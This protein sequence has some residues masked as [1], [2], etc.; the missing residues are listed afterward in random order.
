MSFSR[1][2]S[3]G[4][5]LLKGYKIDVEVDISKGLNSFTIVGLPD[6]S[7]SEAK[8]RVSAAIK[9][10]GFESPKSKNQKVV[11]SLAPANL[12]KEGSNFDLAMALAYLLA[13]DVIRFNPAKKIFLGEL[14]LGGKISPIQ[15]ALLM[16]LEAKRLGFEE[17]YLPFQNLETVN[18]VNGIKIFGISHLKEVIFHLNEKDREKSG[19][20]FLKPAVTKKITYNKL[21]T[22]VDFRD[23]KGQEHVKRAL[24]ISASGKHNIMMYGPPGTGKTMLAKAYSGI[25]PP[26]QF[27]EILETTAIHSIFKNE[28]GDLI[29]FPPFRAPHHTSSYI[30]LIG[31]GTFPKPGEIT[32]AHK[33]VLFMDEFPEFDIRT[34]EA[35]R[36]PIEDKK[37]TRS[38]SRGTI[39]FPSDFVL[40]GAMNPCPCGNRGS[41]FK[42]CN[43][44]PQD[45]RKYER[46]ISGPIIDRIDIWIEV[47]NIDFTKL[48]ESKEKQNN[49][50]TSIILKRVKEARKIQ[51]ERFKKEKLKIET[52]SE[53]GA[54]NIM[55]ISKIKDS[56]IYLLNKK[57]QRLNISPR[58]YHR[59]IR[60]ARTIADL[61]DKL[62]IDEEEILEAFQFRLKWINTTSNFKM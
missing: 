57:A 7:V 43:C 25:L 41:P 10:S 35:L 38:R 22:E 54:K 13:C 39:T 59:T 50:E 60:V 9:N 56:A 1:V 12:R 27:E 18:I 53:I 40:I 34:I 26:L 2:Y 6:K 5:Y 24:E 28:M 44:S 55:K 17:I 19:E 33:G 37:V 42:E 61:K 20:N 48:K 3:A 21:R 45:L 23:I 14:S 30:S 8:D 58:A 46:K 32:L 51:I 11:I 29:L 36:Q 62:L 16:A 47:N 15:G 52:N 49:S 4:V 31:G